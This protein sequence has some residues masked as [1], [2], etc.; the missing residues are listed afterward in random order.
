MDIGVYSDSNN[1]KKKYYSSVKVTNTLFSSKQKL[2][3][4]IS[5]IFL[6]NKYLC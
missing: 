6:E 2:Q 1:R 4:F 5:Y 3:V